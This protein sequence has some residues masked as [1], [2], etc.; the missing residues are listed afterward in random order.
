MHYL[1]GSRRQLHEVAATVVLIWQIGSWD[2]G[3]KSDLCKI[4]QDSGI[5][6][7]SELSLLDSIAHAPSTLLHHFQFS[8]LVSKAPWWQHFCILFFS[9]VGNTHTTVVIILFVCLSTKKGEKAESFLGSQLWV[10]HRLF[11]KLILKWAFEEGC[12][13]LPGLVHLLREW[14]KTSTTQGRRGDLRPQETGFWG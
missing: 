9:D 3:M 8:K 1:N 4:V 11:W 5:W 13:P 10:I 12:I 6:N 14:W 7:R 2:P